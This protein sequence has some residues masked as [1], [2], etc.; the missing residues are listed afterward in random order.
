MG[1][2]SMA[3]KFLFVAI[4]TEIWMETKYTIPYPMGTMEKWIFLFLFYFCFTLEFSQ[5]IWLE[6]I[7]DRRNILSQEV[8]LAWLGLAWV[9]VVVFVGEANQIR[10]STKK[11]SSEKFVINIFF[12]SRFLISMVLKTHNN[13]NNKI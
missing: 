9:F 7:A 10:K 3:T 13:N 8:C 11:F 5:D 1:F 6:L 2:F 4:K 12:W